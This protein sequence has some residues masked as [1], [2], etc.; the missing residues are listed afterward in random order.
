MAQFYITNFAK[1]KW[2]EDPL[3]VK[4]SLFIHK[5]YRLHRYKLKGQNQMLLKA[6]SIP[7][8]NSVKNA[9]FKHGQNALLNLIC[10]NVQFVLKKF[11][12]SLKNVHTVF[13]IISDKQLRSARHG[14][15][16]RLTKPI[17]LSFYCV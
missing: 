7:L 3:S 2:F 9:Q 10:G 5:T 11:L 12:S 6:P 4:W 17:V 16:I 13:A 15:R 8:R 14:D 1:Y